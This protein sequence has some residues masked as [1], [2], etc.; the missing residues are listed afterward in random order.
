MPVRLTGVM[1]NLSTAVPRGNLSSSCATLHLNCDTRTNTQTKEICIIINVIRNTCYFEC[2][3]R[4]GTWSGRSLLCVLHTSVFSRSRFDALGLVIVTLF[5]PCT[6]CDVVRHSVAYEGDKYRFPGHHHTVIIQL[7][8]MIRKP[9]PCNSSSGGQDAEIAPTYVNET[10]MQARCS[11]CCPVHLLVLHF[12]V[13]FDLF[14]T[15]QA[16]AA[17]RRN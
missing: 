15:D 8:E 2:S 16:T 10:L 11:C 1:D 17:C 6:N 5:L 7:S 9:P 13:V 14:Y 3:E 12:A 4:V